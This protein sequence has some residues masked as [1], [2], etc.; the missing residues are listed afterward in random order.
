[1]Q[2]FNFESREIKEISQQSQEEYKDKSLK[3]LVKLLKDSNGALY[4]SRILNLGLY[5][6]IS[7]TKDFK[8]E[9]KR[10]K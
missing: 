9:M 7:K 6:L 2:F 8:E 3:D 1:M 10:E 4:P 5:L